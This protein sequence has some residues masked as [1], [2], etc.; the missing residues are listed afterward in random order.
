MC[1]VTLPVRFGVERSLLS[2]HVPEKSK[3]GGEQIPV[4]AKNSAESKPRKN[5]L[6]T[7]ADLYPAMPYF[8]DRTPSLELQTQRELDLA[9]RSRADR[10]NGRHDR[11]VQV[12]RIDDAA[13]PGLAARWS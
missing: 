10:G 11:R 4:D 12:H 9:R 13:K 6:F 5:R 1:S 3:F 2:F 7:L 8:L